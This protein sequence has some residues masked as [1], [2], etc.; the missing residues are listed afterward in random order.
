MIRFIS[1]L[2]GKPYETC[3]SCET[4]KQQLAV[5]NEEKKELT[6]TLIEIVKPKPAVLQQI[7]PSRP[8]SLPVVASFSRRRA[9]LEQRDHEAARV[10][11]ESSFVAR[12][13]NVNDK[14]IDE[15]VD[16]LEAELNIKKEEESV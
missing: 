11:K 4:L 12:P 5:V 9:I 8:I 6:R 1:F 13:D 14:I 7:E 16:K 2:L 15:A 10:L 3:K